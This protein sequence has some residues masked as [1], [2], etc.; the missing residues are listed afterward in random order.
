MTV[1]KDTADL[2]QMLARMID[3]TLKDVSPQKLGFSLFVFD[4]D[5]PEGSRTN[6]VGNTDRA[7]MRTALKEI[8]AR[9]DGQPRQR[10]SA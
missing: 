5:Q 2:M 6:Y 3:G 4:L 8:I 9:W 1:S 7:S 10:G